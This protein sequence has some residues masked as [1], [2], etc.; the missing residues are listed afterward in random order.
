MPEKNTPR[1]PRL[2][3]RLL[4][5][6]SEYEERFSSLGD[7]DEFYMNIVRR[8]GRR[9]AR[10]WYWAQV[11]GSL[12]PYLLSVIRWRF[13]MFLSYL[14]STFRNLSR[15]KGYALITI[16][17]LAVAMAVSFLTVVWAQYETSFDRFHRQTDHLYRFVIDE[18]TETGRQTYPA[19]PLPLA[20]TLRDSFPEVKAVAALQYAGF[21]YR[22]A[23]GRTV[24]YKNSVY[25]TDSSFLAMFDFPLLKGDP[26]TA[27]QEVGS[28]VLTESTARKFFGDDDPMGQILLAMDDKIPMKVTGV[29]KDVPETSHLRFDMLT[30]E[31]T[32]ELWWDRQKKYKVY[33]DWRYKEAMY[34]LLAPGT[35]VA[36][37][38]AKVAA[39]VK[40]RAPKTE[41]FSLSLQPL[42]DVHLR[43]EFTVP[44]R[45]SGEIAAGKL[46]LRDVRTFLLISL[47]VL[48]VACINYTNLATARS[49][50]RARE[51][52][53]RKA[54]GALRRDI[55]RQFLG[56]SIVLAFI[57]F[58]AA[59]VLALLL[60]P[61]LRLLTGRTFDFHIFGRGRLLLSFVGI[62]LFTGLA[63]GLYPALFVSAFA[64]VAA[65]KKTFRPDRRT[66]V[67]L[68]RAL[69]AV[70]IACSATLI[71][72]TSIITLQL[73]YLRTKDL[74]FD[75]QNLVT[76]PLTMRKQYAAFKAEL[77]QNPAILSVAAGFAPTL[78]KDGHMKE[79]NDISWE[80][81]SA[82][83]NVTMDWIFV[84]EDYAQTYGLQMAEGRFFSKDFPGDKKGFVINESAAK[85]MGLESP[86]GKTFS[87]GKERKGEIIG[88]V[89]DFHTNTLKA[90]I[91]PMFFVCSPNI[92]A[93]V[94][95][96]PRRRQEALRAI[97][98]TWAKFVP[99]RPFEYEFLDEALDKMY[100][101]DRRSGWIVS[102]FGILSI[103]I[104]CLGLFGLVSFMAEQ[105]TKEIGIRK[106][107]GASATRIVRLMSAEF[108][109]LVG[110]AVLLAWPIGYSLAA[111]WLGSYAYKIRLAWWIFAGSGLIV[112]ALTLLTMSLRAVKAARTNPVESLRYE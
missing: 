98:S 111:R 56:E 90:K 40:E 59:V 49:L 95:I 84:D 50:R 48:L 73:R 25:L 34:L 74:G 72:V 3:R 6:M 43:S 11:L 112:F 10:R 91:G 104:S 44:F 83:A 101:D 24:N 38:E 23:S 55:V 52:G 39:V 58:A 36:A 27:L 78:G 107:L 22:F 82:E 2:A 65:L 57:A 89:K 30:P 70:Q 63:S 51:I 13:I 86:V 47:A 12:L 19:A 33:D 15:K 42:K 108:A 103:A 9:A 28:I 1:P 85:A 110:I 45:Q 94:R 109:A 80:G 66:F 53:I 87:W 93:T 67:S 32:F 71:V 14:K 31:S 99:E 18:K 35:D 37:F 81:K 7:F 20:R 60:F 46:Y 69:V 105:R 92:E 54:N 26:R 102:I 21:S 76:F 97:A 16:G 96:D 68:R 88:V 64:P 75:R 100:R 62:T 5:L 106:V 79:K 17:G 41:N 61:L 4:R 8:E 29:L 77:L